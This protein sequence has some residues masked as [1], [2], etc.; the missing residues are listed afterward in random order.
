MSKCNIL[1]SPCHG[2]WWRILVVLGVWFWLS[3]CTS[4]SSNGRDGV[5][6][7]DRA[8][9]Q[10]VEMGQWQ[11]GLTLHR[12]VL[13]TD[14]ANCLAMYHLGYIWG[15]LGDPAQELA[16]YQKAIDCG[17]A[18][19]DALFFNL[20]MAYA[21][22]D[23]NDLAIAAFQRSIRINP[24]NAESHFGLGLTAQ[25]MGDTA[26]AEKALLRAISL[27]PD[28]WEARLLLAKIYLDQGPIEAAR[29]HL[30][31]V[32]NHDPE[33]EEAAELWLLYHDRRITSYDR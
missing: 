29:P 27:S 25:S 18:Q 4:I 1:L 10:A 23:Q 30:E 9:D 19:D 13:H 2:R 3:A 14:P 8:A 5:W 24:H 28:H 21:D 32:L 11:Q 20:G 12:D 22:A 15:R 7:C 31:M 16:W 33:N 17:Y 26:A 6:S